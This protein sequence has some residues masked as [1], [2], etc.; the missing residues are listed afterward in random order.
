M[1]KLNKSKLAIKGTIT[2][3]ETFI[4]ESRNYTPSK[5]DFRLKRVE[6]MNRKIDELKDQYYDI[7]DIS[8]SELEVIEADLQLEDRLEERIRDILNSLIAKSSVSSVHNGE[9]K[10]SQ[11]N[12]LLKLEIK[13]PEIPLPVFRGRYDEWPLALNHNLI[14]L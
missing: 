13:L 10:I 5:L 6:E 9:N 4:E 3:V 11:A 1:D 2:K 14:T 7:K 8:D 12:Y